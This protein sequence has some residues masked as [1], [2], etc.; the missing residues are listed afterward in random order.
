MLEARW[1]VQLLQILLCFIICGCTPDS[2]VLQ[3]V[4]SKL[5]DDKPGCELPETVDE[6]E[7][8]TGMQQEASQLPFRTVPHGVV[9][10]FNSNDEFTYTC[11][12]KGIWVQDHR[13]SP[14]TS[15]GHHREKRWILLL[16]ARGGK[17]L[18]KDLG[19]LKKLL[20]LILCKKRPNKAPS[21][22]PPKLT[23]PNVTSPQTAITGKSARVTWEEPFASDRMEGPIEATLVKGQPSGSMFDEGK[24]YVYY[25]AMNRKG[26]A[27]YCT[28]SFV[29]EV[30]RCL[31]PK[32]PWN[33][34]MKCDDEQ[35]SGS[36]C[37]FSCN[38][39]YE[40]KGENQIMCLNQKWIGAMPKCVIKTCPTV[41]KISHGAL[42]C[43]SKTL[44][45]KTICILKCIKGYLQ[46]GSAMMMCNGTGTW[47]KPG[48]CRD[49]RAPSFTSGCVDDQ[50]A[51]AGPRDKP[52]MVTWTD[53]N[54]TDNSGGHVK[55][56]YSKEKG[57][58]FP[59]GRTTIVVK[60][61]DA[62]KNVMKCSFSIYIEAQVCKDPALG[63][64]LD[65]ELIIYDCPNG[66]S[67]GYSC[68]VSC[69]SD[70]PLVGAS[71]ITCSKDSNTEKLRWT[72]GSGKSKPFC[73]S[74]DCPKLRSP[75]NGAIVC[76]KWN[77]GR[78]CSM[79]CNH[80]YD[81]PRRV[82]SQYVC[83]MSTGKWRPHSVIQD[84]I[85]RRKPSKMRLPAEMYYYASNCPTKT[86][87]KNISNN[88][89]KMLSSNELFKEE[90]GEKV[91]DCKAEMVDVRCGEVRT[92][93]DVISVRGH[94]H[95]YKRSADKCVEIEFNIEMPYDDL[96]MDGSD[97]AVIYKKTFNRITSVIEHMSTIG[98]LEV[99]GMETRESSFAPGVATIVC[100]KGTLPRFD[101]GSCSGCPTGTFLNKTDECEDCPK[102][103]YQATSHASSCTRCP[104]GT[105]TP[106][107]GSRTAANCT[108]MCQVGTYSKNG[109][110]PC[111]KCPIGT[112]QDINGSSTCK[113]CPPGLTTLE[114]G[115]TTSDECSGYDMKLAPAVNTVLGK[116]TAVV[117]SFSVYS[118]FFIS[119]GEVKATLLKFITDNNAV[120][121]VR[122]RSDKLT[123]TFGSNAID[124]MAEVAVNSWY[125]LTLTFDAPSLTI[126]A[127]VNGTAALSKTTSRFPQ[128]RST[129][130]LTCSTNSAAL[131]FSGLNVVD[132]VLGESEIQAMSRTC[133]STITRSMFKANMTAGQ[134]ISPSRCDAYDA[135][136]T[137]PCGGHECIDTISGYDCACADGYKGDNCEIA[138][139]HCAENMCENGA[140]CVGNSVNYT[141]ECATGYKG[142]LCDYEIVHGEW[143]SWSKWSF[144]SQI[145]D[146][147]V[148]TRTRQCDN[149]PPDPDGSP[150]K[151]NTTESASCNTN[152]CRECPTLRRSYGVV[153]SCHRTGDLT[154]CTIKCRDDLVFAEEPLPVYECGAKTEYKWSH[155]TEDH[156]EGRLPPCTPVKSANGF[157]MTRKVDLPTLPCTPD[158]KSHDSV[159]SQVASQSSDLTCIKQKLCKPVVDVRKCPS[160]RR[161]RGAGT[162]V[163]MTIKTTMGSDASFD[164][165]RLVNNNTM[166]MGMRK[167][168]KAMLTFEQSAQQVV[169]NTGKVF[170]VVVNGVTFKPDVNSAT[171]EVEVECNP[172]EV[173]SGG[174][175]SE[176]PAGSSENNGAC[177]PCEQ[178]SFQEA[179]GST[180]CKQC[181]KGKTTLDVG[182]KSK[183]ECTTDP[184][185][186]SDNRDTTQEAPVEDKSG[187]DR[188]MIIVLSVMI[189][190]MVFSITAAAVLWI[191]KM[192][193][194]PNGS[195]LWGDSGRNK[196]NPDPEVEN[197]P[198]P[199]PAVYIPPPPPPPYTAMDALNAPAASFRP[200]TASD[201]Q[202]RV[203]PATNSPLIN[204]TVPA[205]TQTS[206]GP[207][208]S[209]TPR[210]S[211][212]ASPNR[213]PSPTPSQNNSRGSS[214]NPSPVPG[215]HLSSNVN[216]Q[217]RSRS[218]SPVTGSANDT[219]AIQTRFIAEGTT[220]AGNTAHC[221][222]MIRS[223]SA[224][225]N[226]RLPSRSPS[227]ARSLADFVGT[228][229]SGAPS[230]PPP[231]A[232][233]Y[234]LPAPCAQEPVLSPIKR[235]NTGDSGE[236]HPR[237]KSAHRVISSS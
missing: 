128:I 131:T 64:T 228:C 127:Y 3:K 108:E 165:G 40:M 157:T 107:T 97:V 68:L 199:Y 205:A 58:R 122:W 196:V 24:N 226:H 8:S 100:P 66:T 158:G 206:L 193:K 60:A 35:V 28:I 105:S 156:P 79:Q 231:P 204:R 17:S 33:G 233:I 145:C 172:G 70:Y 159:T 104:A 213:S 120:F 15:V 11:T 162:S 22:I 101:K 171:S 110:I 114:Y 130:T 31:R 87:M 146:G 161:R 202:L 214:P 137:N 36:V 77:H 4:I 181:P 148:R 74:T 115:V 141:C 175:C 118:W 154:Q 191:V 221:S 149:P 62:D 71:R 90:C 83:G 201:V 220:V 219:P 82:P 217:A 174:A 54:V 2:D 138:P 41:P 18:L 150:C 19:L 12:E 85:V 53:P 69:K 10:S 81:V 37:T 139:D 169:N 121:A 7:C 32:W 151:G 116:T 6:P 133:N 72:W 234:N 186:H 192:K 89:I 103:T 20:C 129:V 155:W 216:S 190:A 16:L 14:G 91:P 152:Q 164:I 232:A 119:P 215:R 182:A 106:S 160:G 102:G 207:T 38:F 210:S 80:N 170:S 84:C 29:V 185:S 142:D 98:E 166:T 173:D 218:S 229:Q 21:L 203:M 59:L 224:S 189:T 23:C 209:T 197:A 46:A 50:R 25:K 147:G 125:Q 167:Y 9:C 123:M 225:P 135:C 113:M 136:V 27:T 73:K 75:I 26:L 200:N 222:K 184:S 176:C 49:Y 61:E 168:L 187:S 144:C 235:I 163:T 208:P 140:R 134:M 94:N 111:I 44:E 183:A 132:K 57:S 179:T 194:V 52:V 86:S 56:S 5:S 51:L 177:V 76:D 88:F 195:V 227:P 236:I 99:K 198:P 117:K 178:G 126:K 43:K 124:V 1:R 223:R 13:P 42:E 30:S 48:F 95:V 47:T 180:S 63:N 230:T 67:L 212:N 93:R 92:K 153:P 65:R 45:Y 211:R 112:Y 96:S 109:V 55:L 237:V 34:R 78:M 143:S 39:G 188:T